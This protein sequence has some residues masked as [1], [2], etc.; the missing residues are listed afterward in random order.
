MTQ[1][2]QGQVIEQVST[3]IVY[4]NAYLRLREDR[5]RRPD[6]SPG[7]YTYLDKPDFALVIAVEDGGFH[8]VEQ[9]R[10]PVRARSWEFPQ[11]TFPHLATGDPEVLARE[12]LRQETG[13]TA[14]RIR[15]LGRLDS[16]KGVSAQGFDVFLAADLTH[17]EA[18]LEPE[19][20]DLRHQWFPRRE[21]EA[22]I[23]RGDIT[24]AATLAAYT[25]LLLAGE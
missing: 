9:Y 15:H 19:E 22:M 6:G 20:Q 17:G 5:I 12:E 16:A 2:E 8:L 14:G 3:E 4:E 10:Y 1:Q 7:V 25:L 13:L 21:V 11:G 24:D 23:R 18:E